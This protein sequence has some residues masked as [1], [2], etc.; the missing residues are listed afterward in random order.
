MYHAIRD[1]GTLRELIFDS[2]A[3]CY[4]PMHS[5]VE[6]SPAHALCDALRVGGLPPVGTAEVAA[7]SP[8]PPA[9]T[10][11]APIAIS[12]ASDPDPDP[13]DA[14]ASAAAAPIPAGVPP[15]AA[16]TIAAANRA[17]TATAAHAHRQQLAY[18]GPAL[19]FLGIPS[20]TKHITT[21]KDLK[22][23]IDLLASTLKRSRCES[24][25]IGNNAFGPAITSLMEASSLTRLSARATELCA[26]EAS[27]LN[28]SLRKSATLRALDVGAAGSRTQ[29]GIRT[30]S[31][32]RARWDAT[33]AGSERSGI[34]ARWDPNSER[35]GRI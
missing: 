11:P 28:S 7:T 10:S 12:P 13:A 2:E 33:P 1:C 3:I 22:E 24:L 6:L 20:C 16:G 19:R 35:S 17:F 15:P 5:T 25:D 34:R 4:N 8:P 32:I 18:T 23:L 27:L 29:S 30:K 26:D 31:G 21:K 14:S 9:T